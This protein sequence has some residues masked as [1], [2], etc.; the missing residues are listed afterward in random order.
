MVN[1]GSTLKLEHH[2]NAL[3]P[4]RVGKDEEATTPYRCSATPPVAVYRGPSRLAREKLWLLKSEN[5]EVVE[6]A[7]QSECLSRRTTLVYL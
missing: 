1:T 5:G 4:N 3:T 2:P 6:Q 7:T